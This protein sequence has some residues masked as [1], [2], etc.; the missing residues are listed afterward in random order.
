MRTFWSEAD[1]ATLTRL[2]PDTPTV[3]LAKQLGRSRSAVYGKAAGLGLKKSEAYLLSEHACRLRRGDN[4]GKPFRFNKGHKPWNKGTKGLLT[5]GVETQFAPGQKPHN[6]LPIGAE[7]HSKEGYLQRKMTDTGYPPRDWRSVHILL[8]EEHNGPVPAGHVVIF[9]DGDKKHIAIDNL[10]MLTLRENM[11]R[12]TIHR[13]PKE[14][15]D[16]VRSIAV[17]NRRINRVQK[18]Q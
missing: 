7:R 15:K 1:L 11:L 4:V 3:A 17:L 2:Y 9:K 18:H 14:I 8:W 13:Y 6:W 10:E 5:G 16:A 12:N